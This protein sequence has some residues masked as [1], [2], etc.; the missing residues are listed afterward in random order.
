MRID[1]MLSITVMLL[2]RDRI[3]ARELAEKF[4]VSVRT[5]YRDV[6]AINMAG[7]PVISYPGNNGGLGIMDNY[8]IDR[9]VLTLGDMKAILSA[10]KGINLTFEDNKL[11]SAIG[12]ITSLVPDHEAEHVELHLEQVMID[13]L[14]WGYRDRDKEKLKQ[15]QRS[16]ISTNLMSF[17]YRNAKNE[18]IAR[19]V[20]PMT[21]IFKGYTWYLFAYC[22]I[23]KDFRLFR[24]SRLTDLKT[25][26]QQFNRRK[27]SY[28]DYTTDEKGMKMTDL[29]LRF[30]PEARVKV[31]DYYDEEQITLQD[32]GEMIVKVSFPED[33]WIYSMILSYGELA[34]VLEPEHIRKKILEKAKKITAHYN[35]DTMVSQN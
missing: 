26:E 1:R 16:T 7:I 8:K 20:E 15:I 6:D 11:D 5:I 22:C 4:E 29:V 17:S 18:K 13:I 33:E 21:L 25:M 35:P 3:P 12:K 19:V 28:Q 2:N 30:L 14:P 10:L 27:A 32:N 31:F 9:Q 23:R 24:L 34:E